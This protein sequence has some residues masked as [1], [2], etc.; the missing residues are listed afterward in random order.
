MSEIIFYITIKQQTFITKVEKVLFIS[1]KIHNPI[2]SNESDGG[3]ENVE[4]YFFHFIFS[5]S[6]R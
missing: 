3:F 4:N 6:V 1:A 2:I 5:N